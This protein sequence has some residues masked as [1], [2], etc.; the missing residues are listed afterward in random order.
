MQSTSRILYP[1]IISLLLLTSPALA[2]DSLHYRVGV[3]AAVASQEYLPHWATA[4]RFG[5][6]DDADYAVSYLRGAVTYHRSLTKSLRLEAGLDLLAK[7]PFAGELS[8][9]LLLQQG[10]VSLRYGIF[11]LTGGRQQRVLGT[12]VAELT[13]GSLS[14]SG[15]ARPIPQILAAVPEYS[16]VPFT[17][18]YVEFKGTFAHGWMGN[19]R[20]VQGAWLHQKSLFVRVGGPFW[21][22]GS[23]GLV[24][25]VLWG[26]MYPG[27]G[28]LPNGL[29]DFW[30]VVRGKGA[31]G[32]DV[33]I[34]VL[35]GETSA[36]GDNLGVY[37]F[38]L[39]IKTKNYHFLV[40]HQTP[41]ED[42]TGSRLSRNR[43]R[44]LG[45][46]VTVPKADR[47]IESFV[48]EYLYTKYQSG[49]T[50]PGGPG[51]APTDKFGN[52]FGG[53]DNY[54]NNAIYKTGWV[55]QDRIIGTP[56]FFTEARMRHYVPGFKEPD[57]S[58]FDFNVVNN[59]VVAHHVGV[60]GAV[61][62]VGYR[63][64][65]TF[66]T[67]FGTYG[68][69]NGGIGEWGSIENPDAP[70]AFRPAQRQDYYM[71]EVESHPFSAQWSLLTSLA[72]DR[73]QLSNNLGLMVGLRREGTWTRKPTK[74]A[75]P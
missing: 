41:F 46:N 59:R 61:K 8:P 26:G 21:L 1:I 57:N 42:W 4:N 2:Q 22:N 64:L 3:H 29:D 35:L 14:V 56:L 7:A 39:L 34:P 44:L 45:F 47:W 53:R 10:Y 11:E 48:Y 75:Q 54:Y 68:G 24:H 19:D 32:V 30:Q 5:V 51:D 6:L 72:W 66:S 33:S 70:Y 74:A 65:T 16:A 17:R 55:Y 67:N 37:D 40:Y 31:K 50:I 25:N 58:G 52:D 43:D 27:V 28:Q 36:L 62:G 49:P 12:Q 73:G 20:F 63:L 60:K 38:S 23:A 69:I 9:R 15:N 71:L 13:T 18:G